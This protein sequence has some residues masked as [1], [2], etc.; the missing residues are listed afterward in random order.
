MKTTLLIIILF[1]GATNSWGQNCNCDS[2]T[3]L[4][5]LIFCKPI[6]FDNKAKLFWSYNCD[7]SWLTFENDK[8]QQKSIFSLD[9]ELIELTNRLGYVSFEEFKTTFLVTNKV[10]SGCCDPN[11]YYLY[12]KY[13][14]DLVKYLGRAIFVGDDQYSPFI[15]SVT[16]SGYKD[17]PQID[18]NSLTIYNIN[19]RKEFKIP[20]TKNDIKLG[21]KNNRFMF[22]EDVFEIENIENDILTIKYHT[23]KYIRGMPLKYKTITIDFNK[24]SS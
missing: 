14:G 23:D 10:I 2:D 22:P 18:Y 17:N 16:N 3:L 4:K 8:K 1:F 9:K 13:S 20:L 19:T 6:N 21:M 5:D 15:L 7:S 12:D 24:Y 11:D